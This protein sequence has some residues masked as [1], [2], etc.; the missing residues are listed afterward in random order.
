MI[1]HRGGSAFPQKPIVQFLRLEDRGQR[2]LDR[3][4]PSQYRIFGKKDNTKAT[5]TQSPNDSKS[6]DLRRNSRLLLCRFVF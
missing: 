6:T 3:H 2:Q 4:W 5:G 1:E